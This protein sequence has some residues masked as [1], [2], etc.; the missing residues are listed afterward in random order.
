MTENDSKLLTSNFFNQEMA[1]SYDERN[2]KLAAISDN[3][4]FLVR[5]VL[6]V[7]YG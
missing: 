5:L 6:G 2:S 4:H 7:K 1:D 3:M